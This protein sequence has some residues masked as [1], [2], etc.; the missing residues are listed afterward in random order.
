MMGKIVFEKRFT[1]EAGEN[2]TSVNLQ[3]CSRGCYQA[4]M[5]DGEQ[6]ATV[7]ICKE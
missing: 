5:Y 3:D 4:V 7:R 6:S 2:T 1:C